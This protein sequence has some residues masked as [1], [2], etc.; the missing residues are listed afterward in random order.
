MTINSLFKSH[1]LNIYFILTLLIIFIIFYIEIN[2]NP[3]NLSNNIN[4]YDTNK[5]FFEQNILISPFSWLGLFVSFI[6]FFFVFRDRINILNNNL[7]KN[8][9]IKNNLN[10]NN[11]LTLNKNFKLKLFISHLVILIIFFLSPLFLFRLNYLS[12][13]LIW[14]ILLILLFGSLILLFSP[15]YK[16]FWK[17]TLLSLIL[18]N[19][20]IALYSLIYKLWPYF[21]W[22]VG[23]GEF[24][25]I[26]LIYK[27]A[28]F[29]PS[30]T[31]EGVVYSNIPTVG[32]KNFAGV[33]F[34]TCSGIEGLSLFLFL[35]TL[36]VLI[37]WKEINIK[38]VA[39]LYP[40]GL[41]SFFIVNIIRI[42]ILL[43]VGIEGNSEL[44]VRLFHSNT[45][46]ILFTVTF[47]IFLLITYKW[48]KK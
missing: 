3:I 9:L 4:S 32:A 44:T 20:F 41:I 11:P 34:K 21:S 24:F 29:I 25:L 14:Y 33:I 5:F 1:K 17:E 35:F 19:L 6:V 23:K 39:I 26:S 7:N 46:W 22:V 18:G 36:V 48:M 13:L 45:G 42:F 37:D 12:A 10:K 16:L 47:L 2:I 31:Y 28:F 30:S 27:D 15:N 38:K 40:I 43:I 8:I